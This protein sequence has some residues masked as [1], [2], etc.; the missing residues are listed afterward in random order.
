M[1]TQ[2]GIS[3]AVMTNHY[4]PDTAFTVV[5]DP[6]CLSGTVGEFFL[7]HLCPAD[8][9]DRQSVAAELDVKA[10][11]DLPECYGVL[12]TIAD[13]WRAG[14]VCVEM[15]AGPDLGEPVLPDDPAAQYVDDRDCLELMVI[16]EHRPV[17]W[18]VQ[19]GYADDADIVWAWL[20]SMAAL[21]MVDRHGAYVP[22]PDALAADDPMLW[23]VQGLHRRQ[24]LLWADDGKVEVGPAGREVIVANL[25]ETERLI[26]DFNRYCDVRWNRDREEAEFGTGGGADLRV[27]VMQQ[28]GV[29]PLRSVFLLRLYDGSLGELAGDWRTAVAHDTLTSL[30]DPV[31]NREMPEPPLAILSA[32][33]ADGEDLPE[34]TN[35]P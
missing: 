23:L 16:S 21:Y 35:S 28:Y 27:P 7:D 1:L 9:N 3:L 18:A 2:T 4:P 22:H 29:D 32:I 12:T 25:A 30:L 5:V 11:P 31:V 19:Q 10:N 13:Q 34:R 14:L 17:E 26:D 33:I 24:A 20:Q 8:W 6:S 15:L